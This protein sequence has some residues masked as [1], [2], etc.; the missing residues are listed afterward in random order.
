LTTMIVLHAEGNE[1]RSVDA[2][3]LINLYKAGSSILKSNA[4]LT[5]KLSARGLTWEDAEATMYSI[6]EDKSS[7]G[8]EGREDQTN[9]LRLTITMPD[10]QNPITLRGDINRDGEINI[11]D[12]VILVNII[13]DKSL[14][15]GYNMEEA[16][17][18]GNGVINIT[19][20]ISLLNI[21][22]G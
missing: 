11:V 17:L 16:D 2:K 20:A 6:L 10:L 18:D 4:S 8:V 15:Y 19:D 12:V 3:S 14:S 21:I 5:A 13:L 7:Y 1:N 22:L 9:D